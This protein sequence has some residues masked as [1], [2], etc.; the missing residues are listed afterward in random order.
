MSLNPPPSE[1]L[2]LLRAKLERIRAEALQLEAE[3]A[4]R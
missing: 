3:I 4:A 2:E 1:N